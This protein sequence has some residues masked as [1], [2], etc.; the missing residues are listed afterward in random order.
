[1]VQWLRMRVLGMEAPDSN[2]GKFFQYY[3]FAPL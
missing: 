3:F 2:S 1:M